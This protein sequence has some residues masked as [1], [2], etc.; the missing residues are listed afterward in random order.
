MLGV[1]FEGYN[2]PK[3]GSVDDQRQPLAGMELRKHGEEGSSGGTIEDSG[4]ARADQRD[5]GIVEPVRR[6]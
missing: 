5:Q 6:G 2:P 1:F 4:V 3:P